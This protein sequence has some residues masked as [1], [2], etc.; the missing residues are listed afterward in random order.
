MRLMFDM[1][2]CLNFLFLLCSV[3]VLMYNVIFLKLQ[4]VFSHFI[5]MFI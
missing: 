3:S 4:I 1:E 2:I 5:N